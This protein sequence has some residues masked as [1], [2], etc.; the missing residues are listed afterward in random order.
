[1]I[2]SVLKCRIHKI[3]NVMS[4][5]PNGLMDFYKHFKIVMISNFGFFPII[6]SVWTLPMPYLNN[7]WLNTTLS[8]L[9]KALNMMLHAH[10]LILKSRVKEYMA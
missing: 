6:H 1:M 2:P 4:S 3:S 7:L 10:G 5:V 9:L 8:F